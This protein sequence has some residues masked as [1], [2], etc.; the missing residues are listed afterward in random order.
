MNKRLLN[1][2]KKES[3]TILKSFDAY[4]IHSCSDY[5]KFSGRD[6][7]A[8][9]ERKKKYKILK[10]NIIVR[11]KENYIFRIY[12]NHPKSADF[13]SLD[14]EL[15]SS[16][17]K[18]IKTIFEKNFNKKVPCKLT[19]LNHLDE[20]SIIFFKLYKYFFGTIHTYNQLSILKK[21][22]DKL[23]KQD[24]LLIEQS[25]EKTLYEKSEMIKRF[26]SWKYGKF[27]KNKSI[28][29]FFSNLKLKR[30]KKREIFSG[31]INLKNLIF[32]KKFIYALVFG[33]LARWKT[34]HNPMPAIAMVGNDGSGKTS[35]VEY[36]RKHFSKM[37][38]LI[39]DMKSSKPFCSI[40]LKLRK[41]LKKIKELSIKKKLN[42]LNLTVSFI[43]ELLDYI[44]KYIK[45]RIG[46]AW[47]DAG[48]GV[49][50]FE[51]YPTD[52]IRGEFPNLKNKFFPLEQFFPFPDGLIY[53]D[54]LPKDS[55]IRK[56]EG[57]HSIDE[58][59]SKRKNYLSLLKELDEYKKI[60]Y[61][62]N[63][64][65]SL[66]NVKDYLFRIYNKKKL[67][68]QKTKRVKRVIWKKNYNRV[69]FGKNLNRVQ[70][71]S[72]IE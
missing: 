30:N 58:M 35:I 68:I 47:A 48:Y 44:D 61:S 2:L 10:K 16:L 9:Y 42:F 43:G 41:I 37:D 51:R 39:F 49:T 32:S 72:F 11:E 57:N 52:R 19:G 59:N 34:T 55:I 5:E 6:I 1:D 53:L 50:I 28:I 66:I 21:K 45:Y 23:K 20:K 40:V 8:F 31:N 13:L 17:P 67:E 14:I 26:I 36:L 60:S 64:N 46:M 27:Q 3:F 15:T 18:K 56:K 65:Q 63:F 70:R 22:I 71:G 29:N 25:V 62:N 7:D 33:S 38:P 12:I 4:L 69:L 54:V 24:L